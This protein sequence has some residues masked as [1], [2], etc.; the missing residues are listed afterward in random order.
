MQRAV[1]SMDADPVELVDLDEV[2]DLDVADVGAYFSDVQLA[3]DYDGVPEGDS[4][5]EESQ[6]ETC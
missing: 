5:E 4:E 6:E 3:S 1:R 2:T